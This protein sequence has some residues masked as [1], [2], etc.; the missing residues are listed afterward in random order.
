MADHAVDLDR[1]FNPETVAVIGVSRN[2]KRGGYNLFKKVH[3]RMTPRGSRVYPITPNADDIDGIPCFDTIGDLP[4][5]DIDL[6][7]IMVGDVEGALRQ[8]G[9]KNTRFALIFTAG[10][11]EVGEEGA[12]REAEVARIADEAGITIFG[13]N[14]N[15]NAFEPFEDR[16]GR[17]V[18]L[19]TQS[20]HQGRPIVQA[21]QLGIAFNHW[22]P[23]GNEVHLEAADFIDHFARLDDTGAIA[24]YVEGF[25]DAARTRAALDTAATRGVPVVCV[26]VGRSDAGAKMAQAHTGHLTGSDRVV[27]AVFRRYGVIRCEDLDEVAEIAGLFTLLPEPKSDGAVI[28][29]ISGGTGAH[30]ADLFGA[31]GIEL[32]G[33]SDTTQARIREYI[34]D[35]LQV[36]NPV[37]NGGQN[38][39]S[40]EN[41]HILDA[42]VE[43]PATGIVVIPITGVLESMSEMLCTD[44]ADLV[45]RTDVPVV[46]FWGSPLADEGY[47]ILCRRRVPMTRGA[48]NGTKAVRAFLDYKHFAGTYRPDVKIEMGLTDPD[49]YEVT[50]GTMSEHASRRVLEAAGVPVVAEMLAAT[51][52]EAAD[53]ADAIMDRTGCEAVV[54]KI[55]S[56]QIPH[57]SDAGLVRLGIAGGEAARAAAE[58]LIAAARA[59]FP[60][61]EIEG[62]SVQQMVTDAVEIIVGMSRDETFGPVIAVGL[63][64]VYTEVFDDVVLGLPPLDSAMVDEMLARLRSAPLLEGARGA[65]PVHRRALVDAVLAVASLT[66]D[67]RIAELDVNPLLVTPDGVWAADALV[68]GAASRPQP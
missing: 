36:S 63:G 8:A 56:P 45:E 42:M 28:Y 59:G 37:D 6:A 44:I 21:E 64:G 68:V 32:P 43:D 27:E 50:A 65:K 7:L 14:T 46:V 13:P 20:G 19:I 51:P 55:S 41:P 66:G 5:D 67:E 26:K 10:F 24:M 39:R 38:I 61:A 57:K 4:E 3:A 49:T 18:A 15:A 31:A 9:E 58:E 22:A 40:G 53:A 62:V 23:T 60:E 12:A 11:S 25:K 17:K 33:L 29:A 35:Y 48:R 47:R 52:A 2:P 30:V 34:P 54:L 1:F 16:P